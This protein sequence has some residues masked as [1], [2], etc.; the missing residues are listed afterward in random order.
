[1]CYIGAH[2]KEHTTSDD[3]GS[4]GGVNTL[5]SN[6]TIEALASLG[7]TIN[8]IGCWLKFVDQNYPACSNICIETMLDLLNQITVQLPKSLM[9]NGKI[10]SLLHIIGGYWYMKKH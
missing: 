2:E 6:L 4:I 3:Y 10:Q 8:F 9:L 5:P 7:S 1:M